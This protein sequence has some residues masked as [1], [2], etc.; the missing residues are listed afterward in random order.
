MDYGKELYKRKGLKG[1]IKGGRMNHGKRQ[2][3]RRTENL[4][5]HGVP[6]QE[7][8]GYIWVTLPLE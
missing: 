7:K 4:R 6:N 1:R 8:N 5:S 2:G 3:G